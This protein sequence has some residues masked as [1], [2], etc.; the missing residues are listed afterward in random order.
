MRYVNA[1]LTEYGMEKGTEPA[2]EMAA[3]FF[4]RFYA[5]DTALR[6]YSAGEHLAEAIIFML[7]IS[8]QQL[9]KYRRPQR[10]QQSVV[11]HFLAKE[12]P[13]H[14][15]TRAAL[16]LSQSKEWCDTNRYRNKW[17]HEQPP[18]VEGLGKVYKRVKRWQI[19]EAEV[20]TEAGAVKRKTS[21]MVI[22]HG[23]EPEYSVDDLLGFIRPALFVFAE[24]L[25]T[26][27]QFYIKLLEKRGIT[28]DEHGPQ[29]KL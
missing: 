5:D 11:G 22:G 18:T 17:V 12:E 25:T 27:V 14:P 7:E 23:D 10:S 8:D 9:K 13:R 6:L 29:V 16:K 4:G 20:E 3:V 24:T 21:A 26:V 15:I 1:S 19:A 2:N 28:V